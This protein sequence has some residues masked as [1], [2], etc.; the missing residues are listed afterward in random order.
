MESKPFYAFAKA[1]ALFAANTRSTR[2]TLRAGAEWSMAKNYGG[3]L[4]YDITRPIT[5]LMS[6]RPRRYD[7]L[8]ALHRLSAFV[9]DN[10]VIRAGKWRIEAHG[11]SARDGHGP[12][13]EAA[14][15]FRAKS[16][17]TRA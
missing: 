8:P 5:E 16:I 9:E 17:W 2:S 12:T 14:M 15:R 1:M 11:G 7:A 6:T 4:L 3:G 10:T 13:S